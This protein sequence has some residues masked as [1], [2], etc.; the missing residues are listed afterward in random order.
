MPIHLMEMRFHTYGAI[1][2]FERRKSQFHRLRSLMT[3]LGIATPIFFAFLVIATSE[4]LAVISIF[5]LLIFLILF[6]Q[7]LIS[8][9]SLVAKWDK[10]Y[11]S[12]IIAITSSYIVYE[13]LNSL[14]NSNCTISSS[15]LA[16]I[17]NDYQAL[18]SEGI[19]GIITDKERCYGYR[20]SL[21]KFSQ[22]CPSC[23]LRPTGM[24][25]SDCELC[26][27]F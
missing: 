10:Q 24:K 12:S 6:I 9:W 7:L 1:K 15:V 21:I 2:I 20:Q 4:K 11:E 17:K 8:L 16:A 14:I 23:Q 13:R 18:L 27:K 19:S 25:P 3:Y 5:T 22:V 26:G